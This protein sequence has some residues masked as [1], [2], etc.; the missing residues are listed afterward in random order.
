MFQSP[1]L[2]GYLTIRENLSLIGA[3]DEQIVAV[4]EELSILAK[5]DC[6]PH[7]LSGGEKSRVALARVYLHNKDVWLLDEPLSSVD[8]SGRETYLSSLRERANQKTLVY[9]THDIDEALYIGDRVLVLK[10]GEII[11]DEQVL[12]RQLY[13]QSTMRDRLLNLMLNR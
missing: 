5:I 13:G 2:F 10:S 9:V 7:E 8:L 3:S 4:L 12:S 11:Y 6:Y 1:S